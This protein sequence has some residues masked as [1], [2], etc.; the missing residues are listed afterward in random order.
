MDARP[1]PSASWDTAKIRSLQLT[2]LL[3]IIEA[4]QPALAPG[5]RG[6]EQLRALLDLGLQGPRFDRLSTSLSLSAG[7]RL[8]LAYE[9][10]VRPRSWSPDQLGK[11]FTVTWTEKISHEAWHITSDNEAAVREALDKRR[12]DRDREYQ[13]QKRATATREAHAREVRATTPG[14]NSRPITDFGPRHQAF[15]LWLQTRDGRETMATLIKAV[16]GR[17][18]FARL[19]EVSL[20]RI[21]HRIA[22]DLVHGGLILSRTTIGPRKLPVRWVRK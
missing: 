15:F 7:E 20:R 21:M 18:E 8:T 22:D 14:Q 3:R 4:R 13:R 17:T 19:E 11:L 5:E 12:G 10:T 1:P 6:R 2:Q 9:S 16:C